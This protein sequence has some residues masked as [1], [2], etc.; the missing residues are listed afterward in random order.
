[1]PRIL[2]ADLWSAP[3]QRRRFGRNA[4]S[5]RSRRH[6]VVRQGVHVGGRQGVAPD[7]PVAAFHLLDHTPGDAAQALAFDRDHGVSQLLLM[8]WRFCSLL[9]ASLMT[10]T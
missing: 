7:S 6:A 2:I 10:R 1:M 3:N 8:I 4:A 5:A 9:N